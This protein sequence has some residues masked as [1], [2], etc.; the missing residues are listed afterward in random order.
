MTPPPAAPWGS[1][2]Q[3]FCP[4]TVPWKNEA[5]CKISPRFFLELVKKNVCSNT[6]LP[7]LRLA[8]PSLLVRRL[9]GGQALG[10]VGGVGFGGALQK[11]KKRWGKRQNF[12]WEDDVGVRLVKRTR[13]SWF[14][15]PSSS[16]NLLPAHRLRSDRLG[17]KNCPNPVF[18]MNTLDTKCSP[19]AK[20]FF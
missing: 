19:S 8:A 13:P 20:P 15:V 2:R 7:A 10:G 16:S 18:T 12:L 4:T 14:V 6:A 9:Q 11:T 3:I 5:L 17:V 1:L